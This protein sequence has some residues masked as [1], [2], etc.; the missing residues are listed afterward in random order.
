MYPN[1]VIFDFDGTLVDSNS[2]KRSGFY[3]VADS[4]ECSREQV[5]LLLD[6]SPTLTRKEI[7]QTYIAHGIIADQHVST[8]LLVDKYTKYTQS[9][10]IAAPLI[11]GAL[12]IL[13]NLSSKC[14]PYFISSATP[15]QELE[16]IIS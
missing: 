16:K 2:I 8:D 10:V 11:N 13:T 4:F 3:F 14:I 7:F 1:A 6:A 5:D 12:E 9:R 15:Q